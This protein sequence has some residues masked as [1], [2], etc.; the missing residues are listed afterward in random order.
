[1]LGRVVDGVDECRRAV[2]QEIKAGARQ[3]KI[4]ASGGVASPTDPIHFLGFSV[5]ELQAIVEEAA[6]AGS[7]VCAHAYTPDSVRRA[8]EA[9]VRTIEHGNLV[10]DETAALMASRGAYVVPTL[11]T[12]DA[13]AE[14]GRSLGFPSDSLGKIETVRRAGLS[15]LETFQRAGVRM[16]YG[17]DLLGALHSRQSDEFALRT[18]V[19]SN[20]EVICQATAN[21][22]EVLQMAGQLGEITAG[23]FADLLVVDGDPLAD[24]EL[25]RNQGRHL[26][27]IMKG[28]EF[29]KNRLT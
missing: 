9:G 27:A 12:Y 15:S 28:G 3:I 26:D 1:V 13:L 7:Y 5:P 21:G 17:S 29:V 16:A 24:I 19:L 14:E 4:M 10:D 2:R 11:V 25:L 6:A 22:A 23:A 20:F 18:R 8:V